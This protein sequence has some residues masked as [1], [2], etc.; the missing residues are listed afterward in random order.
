MTFTI[1]MQAGLSV[2]HVEAPE[3]KELK[4]IERDVELLEVCSNENHTQQ[5]TGNSRT[6]TYANRTAT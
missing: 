6:Y 1:G 4:D 5:H 2:F 3:H